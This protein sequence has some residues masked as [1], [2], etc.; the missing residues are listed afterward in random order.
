LTSGF[1]AAQNNSTVLQKMKHCTI[2]F[3]LLIFLQGCKDRKESS[4][5]PSGSSAGDIKLAELIEKEG[6]LTFA[7]STVGT[8]TFRFQKDQRVV[9]DSF[10]YNICKF[11]GSFREEEGEILI[12][13]DTDSSEGGLAFLDGRTDPDVIHLPALKVLHRSEGLVLI[14]KD[15]RT[16]FKEHWNIYPHA[17]DNMFPFRILT[18]DQEAEQAGAGQP[19]TRP[20][21]DSE[22]GDKPQPEAEGRSR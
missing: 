1:P 10:A 7:D 4:V 12:S 19:A 16:D 17:I 9:L 14:R 5:S 15:G 22:G 8:C 2:L 20:E 11:R 6:E 21:S 3:T 18:I 13:F